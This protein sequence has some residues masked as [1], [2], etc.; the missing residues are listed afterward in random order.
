MG[1][2]LAAIAPEVIVGIVKLV[3]QI[4]KKTTEDQNDI[5]LE[6]DALKIDM[7]IINDISNMITKKNLKKFG[8]KAWAKE[9][10]N[11]VSKTK[12]LLKKI[13]NENS[14]HSPKKWPWNKKQRFHC[15]KDNMKKLKKLRRRCDILLKH[16]E[17]ILKIINKQGRST[18]TLSMR[19]SLSLSHFKRLIEF[20][21]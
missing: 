19:I 1:D 15:S 3:E 12:I 2:I 4:L 8:I 10:A 18:L 9:A 21:V 5:K 11:L 13:E 16:N 7:G 14:I 17:T 6:L 20:Y